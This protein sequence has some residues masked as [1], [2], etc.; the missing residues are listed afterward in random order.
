MNDPIA[1]GVKDKHGRVYDCHPEIYGDYVVPLYDE[2]TVAKLQ[3]QITALEDA[4]SLRNDVIEE[5]AK[6]I[7]K[8]VF[9]FGA[10]TVSSFASYVRGMKR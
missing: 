8:F 5:V 9:P 3:G 1:Y 6:A 4:A 10:D 2:L 7:D